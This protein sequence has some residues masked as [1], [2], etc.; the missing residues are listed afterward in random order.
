MKFFIA[1]L[2]NRAD[3]LPVVEADL[4]ILFGS[5]ESFSP[6]I[7]WALTDYYEGEMGPGLLRKFVSFAPLISPESLPEIK[8]QTRA[9]EEKYGWMRHEARGRSVNID[10]GYLDAGKVVLASTKSAGHRIYLRSGIYGEVTL[11]FHKGSFEPLVYTYRDY[12]WPET[13]SF[14][15][16]LRSFY[17]GQI[18]TGRGRN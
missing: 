14:F 11:L 9:L 16:A 17:L 8:L 5:I 18:K 10:P 4:A 2:S 6:V 13:I 1:L 12:V 15:S 7:P 3:L